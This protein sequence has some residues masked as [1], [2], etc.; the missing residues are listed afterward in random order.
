MS[1]IIEYIVPMKTKVIALARH[2]RAHSAFEFQERELREL[3]PDEA[4]IEVEAFG[5]NFADVMARRGIYED[6]PPIPAVLGYEVVGRVSR[7]GS[8]AVAAR[9][10]DRVVAFTR[11]GGYATHAIASAAGIAKIPDEMDSGIA[12]A[13]ATQYCTAWYCAEEAVRLHPG[14]HVLVHSAA[15]G[16]GTALVQLAK[17]RG[18]VVYGT[19][20]SPAKIARLKALGVDHPIDTRS[21]GFTAAIRRLRGGDGLDAVFDAIGGSTFRKG[22]HILGVGGRIVSYGIADRA[23]GGK[24]LGTLKIVFGFGLIHPL[25]LL[26]KP[27]TMAGVNMLHIADRKPEILRRCMQSVVALA[28]SGEIKPRVGGVFSPEKIADAHEFLESRRSM[29]KIVVR[30]QGI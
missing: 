6:A 30:W 10:G 14:E 23:S 7:T 21:E 4:L 16:V 19:T 15:G 24:L 18:C 12:C 1:V 3:S 20:G 8:D 17:R 29:G 9:R 5:L 11:F 13:L 28:V 22:F 26:I 2:G 27:R 25:A